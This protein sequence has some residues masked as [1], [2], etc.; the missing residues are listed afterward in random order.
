MVFNIEKYIFLINKTSYVN[1]KVNCTK[2]S[3]LSKGS[4]AGPIKTLLKNFQKCTEESMYY[5]NQGTLTEQEGSIQLT[6]S[7]SF[8]KKVSDIFD[9]V[10]S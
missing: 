6:A 7:I 8:V 2:P 10:M 5:L 1:E 9:A 3:S 4:L